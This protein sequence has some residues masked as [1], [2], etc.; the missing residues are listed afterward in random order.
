MSTKADRVGEI[1][2]GVAETLTVAVITIDICTR[3][4]KGKCDY[5]QKK[6]NFWDE[7]PERC[8]HRIYF[9]NSQLYFFPYWLL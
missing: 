4:N 8:L 3:V 5:K 6:R 2:C 7:I 9:R 1:F